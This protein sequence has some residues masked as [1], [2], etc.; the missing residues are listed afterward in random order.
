[1]NPGFLKPKIVGKFC[2]FA[3][4]KRET[5]GYPSLAKIFAGGVRDGEI[6]LLPRK[7]HRK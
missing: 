4:N 2:P 6:V 5:I 7:G 1:M 3:H